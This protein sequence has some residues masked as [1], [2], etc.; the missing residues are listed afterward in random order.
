MYVPEHFVVDDP[1]EILRIIEAN[2]LGAIISQTPDG[3]N[4]THAPILAQSH[5][6]KLTHL[7]CHLA[8]ANPHWKSIADDVLV[9]FQGVES[10]ITPSWY[11][12]KKETEKVVPTW[13]YETVHVHGTARTIDD[14]DWL[15]AH[16]SDVTDRFEAP[17]DA[18]WATSDGPR[19]RWHRDCGDP[20]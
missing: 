18:P 3:L 11:P 19:D 15:L 9:I 10:Y 8:R 14:A 7:H 16:V 12:T 4:A 2:P 13:N 20:R 6:G 1:V 17:R 5:E